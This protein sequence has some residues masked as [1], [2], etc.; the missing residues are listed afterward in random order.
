MNPYNLDSVHEDIKTIYEWWAIQAPDVHPQEDGTLAALWAVAD[1]L[2][3]DQRETLT[4]DNFKSEFGK[5]NRN[6]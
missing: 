5:G 6:G 4:D 2:V 3:E 1:R